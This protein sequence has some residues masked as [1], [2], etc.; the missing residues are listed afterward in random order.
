LTR[1]CFFVSARTLLTSVRSA[2]SAIGVR[3]IRSEAT[4]DLLRAAASPPV[5]AVGRDARVR[6]S[7]RPRP[8]HRARPSVHG[9]WRPP[10]RLGTRRR[11]GNEGDT[12]CRLPPPRRREDRGEHAIQPVRALHGPAG[13]SRAAGKQRRL[14]AR[15]REANGLGTSAA[16]KSDPGHLLRNGP[17]LRA[18]VRVG[19]DGARSRGDDRFP[20]HLH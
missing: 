7:G 2:V 19:R 6:P 10:A 11:A 20:L 1:T 9:G 16:R 8:G 4:N 3:T 15:G 13:L 14:C 5:H 18:F 12:G 17:A